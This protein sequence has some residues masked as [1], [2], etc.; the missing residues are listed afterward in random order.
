M[1]ERGVIP[2]WTRTGHYALVETPDGLQKMAVCR[3]FGTGFAPK[4]SHFY[5]PY[6]NECDLLKADP[7]WVYEGVAF[8]WRLPDANGRCDLGRRPLYRVYNNAAGGAPNHRYTTNLSIVDAM[9][10][11]GWVYE[12]DGRTLVFACVPN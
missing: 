5:T 11:S 4:S 12:G 1:L 7:I 10:A 3:F 2:G 8:A 6:V 9:Q